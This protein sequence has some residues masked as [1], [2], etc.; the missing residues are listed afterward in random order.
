MLIIKLYI[1][2]NKHIY[3][4]FL[5]P[6]YIYLNYLLFC[7]EKTSCSSCNSNKNLQVNFLTIHIFKYKDII[8]R[9]ALT[10]SNVTLLLQNHVGRCSVC[11]TTQ[12][13]IAYKEVMKKLTSQYFLFLITKSKLIINQV[14]NLY[15]FY[16]FTCEYFITQSNVACEFGTDVS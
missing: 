14:N 12:F 6:C 7:F 9:V 1:F 10:S 8:M 13:R 5:V 2:L 15:F 11:Y 16:I 3:W 4:I